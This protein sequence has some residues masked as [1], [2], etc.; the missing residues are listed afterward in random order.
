MTPA[1]PR[2]LC[3]EML[4][5]L[6]RWLRAAGYD[7]G[8]PAPRM[9]DRALLEL[10]QAEDRLLLSRDRKLLEL[11]GAAARVCVLRSNT[12]HDWIC[13]LNRRYSLDWQ[14]QPFSRCL[15]C[16]TALEEADPAR[17][18]QLPER[19]RVSARALRWC[20]HCRQ[21]YWEGSHVRRMRARLCHWNCICRPQNVPA[22]PCK[23]APNQV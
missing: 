17:R 2:F 6:A 5:G 16:N 3:D 19:S 22:A 20:P 14:L 9:S 12:L 10:A 21:L 13:T 11:R 1:I 15:R 4:Q 23:R 7:T 8:L 18:I